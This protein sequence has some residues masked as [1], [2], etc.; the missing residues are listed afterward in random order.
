MEGAAGRGAGPAEGAGRVLPRRVRVTP[1]TPPLGVVLAGGH[2]RGAAPPRQAL[3]ALKSRFNFCS[4]RGRDQI[5]HPD[6]CLR[7]AP[8]AGR[9]H[10]STRD[11]ERCEQV[12]GCPALSRGATW[13]PGPMRAPGGH[14][15]ELPGRRGQAW[16][17]LA[18][19]TEED[20]AQSTQTSSLWENHWIPALS[21]A[22][23][24][25]FKSAPASWAHL[26]GRIN[27]PLECSFGTLSYLQMALITLNSN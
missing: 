20:Q 19:L 6:W 11:S 9:S 14:V 3:P 17:L 5:L 27:L 1:R 21:Q 10:A 23:E 24:S 22:Q 26:A 16:A 12:V 13:L 25:I 18:S 7:V 15:A 4:G 8:R 2:R